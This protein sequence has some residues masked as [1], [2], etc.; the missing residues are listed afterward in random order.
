MSLC[1]RERERER[2]RRKRKRWNVKRP[3][4]AYRKK[5]PLRSHTFFCQS[6]GHL[7]IHP[8]SRPLS[9]LLPLLRF[10]GSSHLHLSAD[11]VGTEGTGPRIAG[12]GPD[13][14]HTHS[15]NLPRSPTGLVMRK[16]PMQGFISGTEIVQ[17]VCECTE[18]KARWSLVKTIRPCS[19]AHAHTYTHTHMHA[20][21]NTSFEHNSYLY[22]SNKVKN[23]S[24]K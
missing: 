4:E 8:P 15:H 3:N 10:A 19:D 18:L 16:R 17:P 9:P 22:P 12:T 23:S 14:A 24:K 20:R 1:E 7:I 2:E 21:T 5:Y 11:S 6:D 13:I